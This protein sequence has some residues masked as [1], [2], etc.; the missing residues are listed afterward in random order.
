MI[1]STAGTD[2]LRPFPTRVFSGGCWDLKSICIACGSSTRYIAD[3][4]SSCEFKPESDVDLA[5]SRILSERNSFTLKNG[6]VFEAGRS[7]SQL[8]SIAQ[9]IRLGRGYDFPD[10]EVSAVIDLHRSYAST[11]NRAILR[12]LT[13]LFLPAI[14]VPRGIVAIGMDSEAVRMTACGRKKPL[15][16]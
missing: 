9:D 15:R 6:D 5:K 8:E 12:T 13:R 10:E 3:A 14:G 16:C 1:D 4:C 2:A 7:A 11:G